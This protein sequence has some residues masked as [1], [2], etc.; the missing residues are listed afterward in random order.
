[1]AGREMPREPAYPARPVRGATVQ[2]DR[3]ATGHTRGARGG[4]HREAAPG[5][6]LLAVEVL[7]PSTAINDLNNKKA[8]YERLGVPSYWVIDPQQPT[9][10][11]FELDPDGHYRQVAEVKGED[12]F[13]PVRPSPCAS[14]RSSC[15]A[16]SPGSRIVA[17]PVHSPIG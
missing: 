9:L 1:P 15:W 2:D 16:R 3:T 8:A 7:S 13:E 10:I 11:A 6:S 5:R 12:A 17:V 4:P 14:S